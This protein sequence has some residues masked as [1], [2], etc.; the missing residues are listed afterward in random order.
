[1]SYFP[2]LF[3]QAAL[4]LGYRPFPYPRL[5]SAADIAIRTGSS[6]RLHV[7]RL[8]HAIRMHDR[9]EGPAKQY[10]AASADETRKNFTLQTGCSVRRVIH[11]DGKAEGVTI[12]TPPVRKKCSQPTWWCSRLGL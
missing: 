12:L 3:R 6:G 5:P 8:L 1:M 2:S 10:I 11:R 4:D 7:L 9:C